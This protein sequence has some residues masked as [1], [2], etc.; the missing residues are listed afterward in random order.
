MTP[1]EALADWFEA[2]GRDMPWRRTRD[3]YAIWVSEIMLQ[4]TQ[5]TTV[6][7]YYERF[8]TRWPTLA[9]LAAARLDDVMKAWE[10]LGYYARC[11]NLHRAVIKVV[12]EHDGR[13]PDTFEAVHALPGVGRS[14]A[15]A[16]LTFGHG[17]RWPLLDGNV[18]RVL[19]RVYDVDEVVTK[20][21]VERSL[22]EKSQAL[23]EEAEDAWT[24]NQAVMELGA[25]VCTPRDP[26]CDVCPL[27]A[28]CQARAAGTQRERPVKK[29]RKPLPHYDIGV[30]VVARDDG[31]VLVQLRPPKGLL[32]GLWE[33]PGGKREPGEPIETT[34]A[35]ELR[36]ELGIEVEVGAA[37]RAVD[38]RYSHFEITLHAHHCRLVKGT[39]R[40]LEAVELRWLPISELDSLA[41]PKAN[42]VILEALLRES[43]DRP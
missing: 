1:A 39:P 16:I 42:R 17:Q 13:V 26:N 30:G 25:R 24:H 37:I 38:H 21:A 40:P 22:W 18:K 41:F 35:R 2:H 20:A 34:V 32:G 4:Q 33:F 11:R 29:A 19:T 31:R 7:P 8:L 15:G 10:G 5:V 43:G 36:E 23:L 28:G 3:P 12:A 6:L 9:A 14:T 27:A